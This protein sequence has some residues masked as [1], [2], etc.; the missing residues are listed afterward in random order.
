[1]KT[2]LANIAAIQ[3][4]P[5]LKEIDKMTDTTMFL[6]ATMCLELIY[7]HV[8]PG[9]KCTMNVFQW[10]CNTASGWSATPQELNDCERAESTSAFNQPNPVHK[11]Y[12]ETTGV[13]RKIGG[14]D[15]FKN[16]VP[17]TGVEIIRLAIGPIIEYIKYI[18]KHIHTL[19]SKDN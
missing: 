12:D 3:L 10:S 17:I 8:T 14:K 19:I 1:M 11:I 13:L 18:E 9:N 15:L 7:P 16:G 5:S 6:V 2:H 4:N